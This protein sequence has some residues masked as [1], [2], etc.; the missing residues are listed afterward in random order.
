[1]TRLSQ[2]DENGSSQSYRSSQESQSTASGKRKRRGGGGGG[3]KRKRNDNSSYQIT[4]VIDEDTVKRHAEG[5]KKPQ[6]EMTRV[7]QPK[8]FRNGV[9]RS[10]QLDGFSWL[11][12]LYKNG[13]N[14]ILGDEMGLGK[15]VQFIALV[16]HLVEQGVAGPF[17]VCAPLS[18]LP[19][20]MAEFPLCCTTGQ[21]V[22][23]WRR[24][25]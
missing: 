12:T 15:T 22:R 23:E 17:L 10:Y 5:V 2:D 8:L 25:R 19:N 24:G 11:L 7:A 20:W 16:C 21:R 3:G 6:E 1:M 13:I 14:G 9:L 18:T 4:D